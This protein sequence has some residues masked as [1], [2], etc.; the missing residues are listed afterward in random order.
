MP[1]AAPLLDLSQA[2]AL[3]GEADALRGLVQSFRDSLRIEL[4]RLDAAVSAEDT[5]ALSFGLHAL[6]GF[7][8][9]F[10]QP[11]LAQAV[12]DLYRDSRQQP[13]SAIGLRYRDLAPVLH[14]LGAEVEVWL[15]AL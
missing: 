9:L 5:E 8:P 11:D 2:Q 13:A 4:Q 1:F 3:A 10:C 15:G 12:T 7:V 6:K 14:A